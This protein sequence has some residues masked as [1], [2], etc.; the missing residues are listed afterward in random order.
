MQPQLHNGK[1]VGW[2]QWSTITLELGE[3]STQRRCCPVVPTEGTLEE[4]RR[5]GGR[6]VALAMYGVDGS[7]VAPDGGGSKRSISLQQRCHKQRGGGWCCW[8]R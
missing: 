4:A 2:V 3:S 6:Q 7:E 1:E 8:Q 5:G